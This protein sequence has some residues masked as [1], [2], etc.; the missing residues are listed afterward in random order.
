MPTR[1]FQ[2]ENQSLVR[3]LARRLALLWK[4]VPAAETA[5]MPTSL[6]SPTL[7]AA[8]MFTRQE[9]VVT[10]SV[11]FLPCHLSPPRS[12]P[13]AHPLSW[14]CVPKVTRSSSSSPVLVSRAS[15]VEARYQG[16]GH[17]DHWQHVVVAS[18]STGESLWRVCSDARHL[19][20]HGRQGDMLRALRS[21]ACQ[22]RGCGAFGLSRL[23]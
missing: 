3:Y 23:P 9:S 6:V 22:L 11:P 4:Q 15:R 16:Q 17:R 12:P 13:V 10:P 1:P 20:R 7:V 19:R 18:A 5:A 21:H 2:G 14:P 8:P